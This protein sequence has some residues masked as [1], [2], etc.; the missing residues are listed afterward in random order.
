M[1]LNEKKIQTISLL[2]TTLI[3]LVVFII[4]FP[5]KKTQIPPQTALYQIPVHLEIYEPPPKKIESQKKASKKA[6][7]K[8]KVIKKPEKPSRLPGD[9]DQ[10]EVIKQS[11]KK[12]I[13]P[14]QALNYEWGGT[15]DLLLTINEKGS[16]TQHKILKSTGHKVLDNTF[17]RTV[18]N[19]WKFKPKKSQG[20]GQYGKIKISYTFGLTDNE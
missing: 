13:Y 6:Y 9:R 1:I 11:A 4:S 12:P 16:V 2:F 7:A 18:K 10:P 3:H 17:I 20:K 5:I 8:A 15:I 19:Y 14:K